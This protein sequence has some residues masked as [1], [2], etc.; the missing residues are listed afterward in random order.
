[1][2]SV[3]LVR[4][5]LAEGELLLGEVLERG[6]DYAALHYTTLIKL[7]TG[8]MIASGLHWLGSNDWSLACFKFYF[9]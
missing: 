7:S 3:E 4:L 8:M 1:M 6:G 2:L 5:V 9:D